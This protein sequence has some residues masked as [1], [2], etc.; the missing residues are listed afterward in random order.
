MDAKVIQH[1]ALL[2]SV[3]CVRK[4]VLDDFVND[5]KLSEQ[6]L[7]AF[8]GESTDKL[9]TFL[10]YLLNKSE[11]EKQFFLEVMNNSYPS[12]WKE[13][14][15]SPVFEQAVALLKAKREG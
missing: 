14:E 15:I 10:T 3:N 1:M 9:Y 8:I 4:T 2:M 13:P 11:Q 12:D 7:Q 6:D 5:G